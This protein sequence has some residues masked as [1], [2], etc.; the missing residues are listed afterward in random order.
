MKAKL[1]LNF[2]RLSFFALHMCSI[3]YLGNHMWSMYKRY[4]EMFRITCVFP[5]PYTVDKRGH[6][7]EGTAAVLYVYACINLFNL[8]L[9]FRIVILYSNKIFRMLFERCI[10]SFKLL[11]S[12]IINFETCWTRYGLKHSS[13]YLH[14]LYSI[15]ET[16]NTQKL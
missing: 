9:T 12:S 1:Q 16:I 10:S 5:H 15:R 4:K 13:I 8:L 3:P 6:K 11:Y 7:L 2:F 14:L